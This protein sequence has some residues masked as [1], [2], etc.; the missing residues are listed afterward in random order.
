MVKDII[1]YYSGSNYIFTEKQI[2]HLLDTDTELRSD[3]DAVGDVD[4]TFRETL[5]DAIVRDVGCELG[6][7][8]T[9][10]DSQSVLKQFE[11]EFLPKAHAKG[12]D[13]PDKLFGDKK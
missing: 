10:A 1:G 3:W 6:R 4:T 5:L 13:F 2:R 11:K 8:P 9:Y 7:W 12:Y